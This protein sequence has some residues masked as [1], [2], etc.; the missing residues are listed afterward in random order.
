MHYTLFKT[1][2]FPA[3]SRKAVNGYSFSPVA[4]A[5]LTLEFL[6]MNSI[7]LSNE[8]AFLEYCNAI[9]LTA[10]NGATFMVGSEVTGVIGDE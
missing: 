1:P 3:A 7:D 2:R 4:F 9:D 10:L 8:Q 6:Q 5:A